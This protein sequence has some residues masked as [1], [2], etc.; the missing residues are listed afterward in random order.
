MFAIAKAS[1][2]RG[3]FSMEVDTNSHDPFEGTQKL[4]DVSLKYL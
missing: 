1:G 3:Y 4:V 2:Y